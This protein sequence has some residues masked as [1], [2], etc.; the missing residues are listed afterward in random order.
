MRHSTQSIA[1]ALAFATM[2]AGGVSRADTGESAQ[3]IRDGAPSES[4]AAVVALHTDG[5][6]PCSGTLIESRL[7]LTAAHCVVPWPP[8][9]V[10]FGT[11]AAEKRLSVQVAAVEAHPDFDDRT[12]EYDL[13]VVLLDAP[14]EAEPM[15]YS[16]TPLD[17][18]VVGEAVRLVGFGRTEPQDFGPPLRRTGT[19]R[20]ESLSA[21]VLVLEPAP[22]V[23]CFGDSGGPVLISDENGR[24]VVIGVV[25]AGDLLCS[26]G[27]QA[28]RVDVGRDFVASFDTPSGVPAA[29]GGCAFAP[30]GQ[31][32]WGALVLVL[33]ALVLSGR[34]LSPRATAS[35]RIDWR[36]GG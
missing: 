32:R 9:E 25:S 18:D 24:D 17:R 28:M 1:A 5:M 6:G 13:A 31:P 34:R 27:G 36:R 33:C 14:V 15:A 4:D 2:V 22:A 35:L 10:W 20:I 3:A 29:N 8:T 30:L 7:V 23:P 12:L 21:H 16:Q 19:A 26:S 11:G